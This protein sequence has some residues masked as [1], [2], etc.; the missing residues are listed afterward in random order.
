MLIA[1]RTEPYER[2]YRIRLPPWRIW[3]AVQLLAHCS[4]TGTLGPRAVSA[5]C[6]IKRCS[7]WPAPFSP[8]SPPKIALLCSSASSIVWRGPTPLER[9]RPPCGL[10][11]SRT[12]LVPF[13]AEALQR[14]PGS[15]A[16]CFSACAGSPTTQDRLLARD[17]R[18]TAVVPS[19]IRK[20]SASWFCV[21]RSSIAR[22]TDTP[23]YASS[24]ISRCHLQ[25]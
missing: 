5:E 1:P 2:H 25:D 8:Q 20:E 16:C 24:G 14:S 23:V 11:P 21:F 3:R 4:I 15:R 22:P 10:A 13:R 9:A 12:G 6:C 19:S 17:Y 18:E 7:P